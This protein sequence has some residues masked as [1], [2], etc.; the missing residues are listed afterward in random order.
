MYSCEERAPSLYLFMTG[1]MPLCHITEKLLVWESTTNN[2]YISEHEMRHK[3]GTQFAHNIHK[4]EYIIM[5]LQYSK[6]IY[7]HIDLYKSLDLCG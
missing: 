4:Y 1:T 2:L 5:S 3:R 6:Y 7:G